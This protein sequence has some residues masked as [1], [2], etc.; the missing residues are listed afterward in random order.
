MYK[1]NWRFMNLIKNM[2]LLLFIILSSNTH[3]DSKEINHHHIDDEPPID[4]SHVYIYCKD[5]K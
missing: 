2:T 1:T 4:I 3:S 5:E